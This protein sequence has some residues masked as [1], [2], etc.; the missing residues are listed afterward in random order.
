MEIQQHSSC[1]AEGRPPERV[2][3]VALFSAITQRVDS[4]QII[5]I[6]QNLTEDERKIVLNRPLFSQSQNK[7]DKKSCVWKLQLTLPVFIAGVHACVNVTEVLLENGADINAVENDISFLHALIWAAAYK[8]KAETE[9]CKVYR[10]VFRFLKEPAERKRVLYSE[11]SDGF[12]PIELAAKLGTFL[13]L[14]EILETECVYKTI[15]YSTGTYKRVRYDLTEYDID[16]KGERHTLCPLHLLSGALTK[17]DLA[18]LGCDVVFQHK[19]IQAWIKMKVSQRYP[20]ILISLI[21]YCLFVTLFVQTDTLGNAD[22]CHHSNGTTKPITR[23]FGFIPGNSRSTVFNIVI[24]LN[25]LAGFSE[26]LVCSIYKHMT[27]PTRRAIS[28]PKDLLKGTSPASKR[29][30][31][32]N[33]FMFYLA[34]TVAYCLLGLAENGPYVDPIR[35][36][37]RLFMVVL[38]ANCILFFVMFFPTIGPFGDGLIHSLQTFL[39]FSVM[40]VIPFVAMAEGYRLVALYYCMDNIGFEAEAYYSTFLATINMVDLGQRTLLPPPFRWL[41]TCSIILLNFL[42]FNFLVGI[43][44]ESVS[45][46]CRNRHILHLHGRLSYSL[47]YDAHYGVMFWCMK[48]L[49]RGK[50]PGQLIIEYSEL[51]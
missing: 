37:T 47:C 40:T 31:Q 49:K 46:V 34:I 39:C 13:L 16:R 7:N 20:V 27:S 19:L 43:L 44:S 24:T 6:L 33:S 36:I 23:Q 51:I 30:F 32:F 22:K 28:R 41:H 38:L 48:L 5:N 26:C 4:D 15:K 8:P 1:V 10:T 2:A 42:M 25:T 21:W 29:A 3:D 50:D 45:E 11:D 18:K 14:S 12:R 9:L 35:L 17:Q